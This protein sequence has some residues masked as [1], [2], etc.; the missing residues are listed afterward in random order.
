MQDGGALKNISRARQ[1]LSYNQQMILLSHLTPN[2]DL[3]V[4]LSIDTLRIIKGWTFMIISNMV[5]RRIGRSY[6]D[7]N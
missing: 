1:Q 4:Y 5:R 7:S 3:E 6:K 2:R